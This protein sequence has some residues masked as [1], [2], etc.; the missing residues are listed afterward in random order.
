MR[1]YEE[2]DHSLQDIEKENAQLKQDAKT[3]KDKIKALVP[4]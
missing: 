2:V 1:I 3:D 4:F